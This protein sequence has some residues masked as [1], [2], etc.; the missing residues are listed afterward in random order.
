MPDIE[1]WNSFRKGDHEAFQQIYQIYAKDLLSYGYKVTSNVQL[2]EDSIHDLFIELWQH[3]NNLSETD[4][5]K[6]YL[7]RSLRNKINNSQKKDLLFNSTDIGNACGNPD[8]FLIESHLIEL[9]EKEKIL[10]QLRSSYTMLSP[11]Q[12]QALNL[13]FYNHFSNEEIARIMGINYQSACKFIYSGLKT[14]KETVRIL[15]FLLI[16]SSIN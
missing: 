6:F 1:L 7:F 10:K 5:I 9:E 2:I 8:E 15:S 16:L 12:Q 3:G 14:L 13:R 4:S 11:R